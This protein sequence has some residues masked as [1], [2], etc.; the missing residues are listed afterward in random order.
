MIT[1]EDN[2]SGRVIETSVKKIVADTLYTYSYNAGG[3]LERISSKLDK[4]EAILANLLE[5]LVEKNAIS[6]KDLGDI[7]DCYSIRIIS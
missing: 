1:Y 4:A 2:L 7:L 5:F 3:E 6:E